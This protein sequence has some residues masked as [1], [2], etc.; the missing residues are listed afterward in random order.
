[1]R[2]DGCFMAR[3]GAGHAGTGFDLRFSF[4]R[5]AKC[6]FRAGEGPRTFGFFMSILLIVVQPCI[7]AIGAAQLHRL[8]FV[9]VFGNN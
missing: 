1:M 6:A 2:R 8:N 5:N 9:D 7:G 3:P 4:S